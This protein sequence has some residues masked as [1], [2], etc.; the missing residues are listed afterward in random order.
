MSVKTHSAEKAGYYIA[1]Y[2]NIG[3]ITELMNMADT[4]RAAYLT[5]TFEFIP[6]MPVAFSKAQSV[7]LDIGGCRSS[8]LPAKPDARFEYTS[9][10]WTAPSGADAVSGRVTFVAGHLHDGGTRLE[11]VRNGDVV[12]V[13]EA[14][15]SCGNSLGAEDLARRHEHEHEHEHGNLEVDEG[16]PGMN[17]S[18]MHIS[19]M[20]ACENVGSVREGDRWSVTARYD[21]KMH[22]PMVNADGSLEPIMGIALIYVSR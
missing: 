9:P 1:P 13:T 19:R 22:E 3:F 12:C 18:G 15:Y 21:T 8:S 20:T 6:G 11:V 10:V 5:V 4:P 17:M 2:E 16:M 14:E 7:W